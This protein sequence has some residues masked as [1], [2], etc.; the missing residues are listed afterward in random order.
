MVG[1]ESG[2]DHR[3]RIEKIFKRIDYIEKCKELH[4]RVKSLVKFFVRT[5]ICSPDCHFFIKS[6]GACSIFGHNKEEGIRDQN[7]IE[8]F[9]EE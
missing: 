6:I 4:I 9:G 5:K 8:T 1:F 2:E 3:K 7:C